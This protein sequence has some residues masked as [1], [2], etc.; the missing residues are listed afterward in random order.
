MKV[1]TT[2]THKKPSVTKVNTILMQYFLKIQLAIAGLHTNQ[3]L[4]FTNK[5]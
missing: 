1:E 4:V 5:V 3:L 2:H